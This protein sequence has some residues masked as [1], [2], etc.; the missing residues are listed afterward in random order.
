MQFKAILVSPNTSNSRDSEC[1]TVYTRLQLNLQMACDLQKAA[2]RK[3]RSPG[4]PKPKCLLS[5]VRLTTRT[6][7]SQCGS[8][9]IQRGNRRGGGNSEGGGWCAAKGRS[10]SNRMG[11][12]TVGCHLLTLI[13]TTI[14][15]IGL[16]FTDY[17]P[18][19][20]SCSPPVASVWQ[21][22][23]EHISALQ[24]QVPP[25]HLGLTRHLIFALLNASLPL[26]W[27]VHCNEM[28]RTKSQDNWYYVAYDVALLL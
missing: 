25:M 16:C 15:L 1:I 19:V 6:H 22:W 23:C 9:R 10:C 7:K 11:R 17:P 27:Q 2:D 8:Q 20:P 4:V 21:L 13:K 14:P 18:A 26:P 24:L 5:A 12:P 3:Q 28:R